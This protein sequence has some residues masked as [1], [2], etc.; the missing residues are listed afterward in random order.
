MSSDMRSHDFAMK[1]LEGPDLPILIPKVIEWDDSDDCCAHPVVTKEEGRL[2]ATDEPCDVLI[3]SYQDSPPARWGQRD[4]IAIEASRECVEELFHAVLPAGLG[5]EVREEVRK[6]VKSYMK[7]VL[8]YERFL[9]SKPP[10]AHPWLHDL[11]SIYDNEGAVKWLAAP[12]PLLDGF[13]ALWCVRNGREAEVAKIVDQLIS[14][15]YL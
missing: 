5:A 7:Q 1:L 11:L 6:Q 9:A 3:I 2:T 4:D 14:G 12:C 15:A 8:N 13:S 10:A